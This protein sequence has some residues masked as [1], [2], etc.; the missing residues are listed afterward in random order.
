MAVRYRSLLGTNETGYKL[1]HSL[2]M[3]FSPGCY[4]VEVEHS[5]KHVGLPVDFCG[6]EHYIVGNL[7][8]SDS[9]TTGLK[10][11]NRVTGQVLIF[12]SRNSKETR[13]FARTY[14]NGV[15]RRWHTIADVGIFR[16]ITTTDE[17]IATVTALTADVE[18]L[19]GE[20]EGSLSKSM[21]DVLLA[22]DEKV[23][24]E[25]VRADNAD[26]ELLARLQGT[27]KAS[28]PQNDSFKR[29]PAVSTVD[30]MLALLDSM[31][32]TTVNSTKGYQGNF[33]ILVDGSFDV[34]VHTQVLSY[35]TDTWAQEITSPLEI[36]YEATD[37]TTTLDNG[38]YYLSRTYSQKLRPGVTTTAKGRVRTLRRMCKNGVWGN[39]V[40]TVNPYITSFLYGKNVLLLGGS[41]AHNTRGTLSAG[42]GFYV[43]ARDYSLQDYIAECMGLARLDNYAISG[44]GNYTGEDKFV[45]NSYAQ[46]EAAIAHATANGYSYDAIILFGGINDYAANVPLGNLSDE[47]GDT[48]F[49]ASLKKIINK[50]RTTYKDVKLFFTTPFKGFHSSDAF[51]NPV[52]V[53]TNGAGH[54]FYEYVQAIKDVAN[55]ASIPLLDIFAIH[56]VDTNNYTAFTIDKLHPNGAGYKNI[57]QPLLQLLAWGR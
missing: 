29:L 32:G 37:N 23:E 42:F 8:V 9:G 54:R 14:A 48:S 49:C 38:D 19:N 17:L 45:Y 50:A 20:G 13:I 12:T 28:D 40:D 51:F 47:M 31:H 22:V 53:V 26:A 25:A 15:W 36:Y 21:N 35:A 4:L 18:T 2:D 5:E 3:I 41:F 39:W 57:A 16:N 10:Q 33:R 44:N 52:S 6:D 55:Y 27:S 11:N 56:Q 46:L 30:D 24:Q 43:D 7:F 1:E 34:I